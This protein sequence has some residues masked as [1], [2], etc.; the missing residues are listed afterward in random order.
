M[1]EQ[2]SQEDDEPEPLRLSVI[3]PVWREAATIT[4]TLQH[5]A[6]LREA[7]H[8]VIVVDGGSD[9]GTQKLAEP[10]CDRV[11]ASGRGRAIQMNAGAAVATGNVLLFLHADTR[12]P[13]SVL[14]ALER[15]QISRNAWGRFNVRLS[16]KRLLFRVVEWFMNQRSW[17]TGIATGDQALFVRQPV[18][19]VLRGY[20]EMPLM[21]D[22]ELCSRLRLV[23]RPFCVSDPVVTDSRRWEQG[24]AWRTIFLM[25][26]LRWRYWRGESPETLANAYRSDVRNAQKS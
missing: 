18:F 8:Q 26:R 15:F 24:G 4:T 19:E 17:L 1:S 9:D 2:P 14:A 7:G 21:E 5:L 25:W 10:L 16:G 13:E 12:L 11:L 23:S 6:P 22:V 20:R 3:V